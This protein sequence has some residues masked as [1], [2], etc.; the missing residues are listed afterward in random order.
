MAGGSEICGPPEHPA[1]D[2]QA[3]T[4]PMIVI[5]VLSP[6]TEG[7]DDGDK[8]ADFQSLASLRAY[9][10]V[11]QDER[12]LKIYRR[13]GERWSVTSYRDGDSFELPSL[14]AAVPV[15]EIYEGIVDAAGRSLLR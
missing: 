7:D 15:A 12:R 8:R 14:T 5:E 10:L 3:T 9:V 4:N 11:S 6:S 13:D 1:H 2:D